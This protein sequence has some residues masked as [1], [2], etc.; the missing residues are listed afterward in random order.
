[1]ICWCEFSYKYIFLALLDCYTMTDLLPLYN[2]QP[3][4]PR[5]S[6]LSY[7]LTNCL[8]LLLSLLKYIS[9]NSLSTSRN[10][11]SKKYWS[12]LQNSKKSSN[13]IGYLGLLEEIAPEEDLTS[14]VMPLSPW[15]EMRPLGMRSSGN[16]KR[17]TQLGRWMSSLITIDR[18]YREIR[19]SLEVICLFLNRIT[20]ITLL[21]RHRC[22]D[23]L[24]PTSCIPIT[25]P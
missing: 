2:T 13:I 17:S 9:D 14:F 8:A 10:I 6:F 25:C 20:W 12:H 3:G 22:R 19:N 4:D 5:I 21:I 23:H 7:P 18:R 11:N 24:I 1:M 15:R 16:C